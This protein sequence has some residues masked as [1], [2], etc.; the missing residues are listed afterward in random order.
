MDSP[1]LFS[2]VMLVL[3]AAVCLSLAYYEQARLP[4]WLEFV[5]VLLGIVL[6][7]VAIWTG[8]DWLAYH[9]NMRLMEWREAM[10]ITPLLELAKEIKTMTPEQVLLLK[11]ARM[12]VDVTPNA[13]GPLV[14]ASII[15]D[16]G[17]TRVPIDFVEEF[18]THPDAR[19][20]HL[21]ATSFYSESA[22][23]SWATAITT[24]VI[25]EGIASPRGASEAAA[26][27]VGGQQAALI[28]FGLTDE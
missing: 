24:W 26:W 17:E 4:G 25:S 8:I 9:Y 2:T 14:F 7:V 23:R 15:G 11:A 22:K 19:D 5:L 20:G 3:A 6:M 10:A 12:Q 18:L 21:L 16:R 27:M 13:Q 28:A 1:K